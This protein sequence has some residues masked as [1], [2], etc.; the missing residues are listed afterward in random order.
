ML[1]HKF[2][3]CTTR[4]IAYASRTLTKAEQGYSQLER[5]ALALVFGV[6]KFHY[7]LYGRSFTLI[8][9]HKPLQTI[10]GPKTGIPTIAAAR[11]QRWAVTLA[12]YRYTLLYKEASKNV[13]ADCLSR[14]PLT[15]ECNET[16]DVEMFYTLRL[17]TMPL[18]SSDIARETGLDPMPCARDGHERVAIIT[19]GPRIEAVL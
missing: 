12:A 11:L 6:G 9:D 18:R 1:S 14:M 13:E 16:A 4:P 19:E 5:E 2:P 15:Y 3:D 8:T 17:D 7:Y 10:F